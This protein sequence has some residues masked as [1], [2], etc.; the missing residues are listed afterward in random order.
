MLERTGIGALSRTSRELGGVDVRQM[1]RDLLAGKLALNEEYVE[2]LAARFLARLRA[3]LTDVFMALAAPI[4]VCAL[5]RALMDSRAQ[6]ASIALVCRLSCAA[7]M[8]ERFIRARAIAEAALSA[9]ARWID[10]AAPVLASAMA[11]TGAGRRAAILTPSTAL[12]AKLISDLLAGYGLPLCSVAAAVA[13][14]ANLSERFRL[15]RLFALIL[16]AAQWGAGL[17]TAAFVG[18]LSLQGLLAAGQDGAAIRA[19]SKLMRAA[20]PIIGGE[21]SDSSGALLSSAVAVRNAVG[22]AGMLAGAS[23]CAA[24]IARLMLLALSLK[25]ASSVM[26]PV[27]DASMARVVSDFGDL[28]RLLAALCACATLMS[29]LC[30][31]AFLSLGE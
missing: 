4:L 27:A 30:L 6:S 17:L 20:L 5:L 9:S 21:L 26:E 12:C 14:S 16:R 25:L 22:V 28:A 8:M 15:N 31:G 10:A 11:L 19:V 18:L 23:V 24:P 3:E 1:A 2:M 29:A 7:L 13:A